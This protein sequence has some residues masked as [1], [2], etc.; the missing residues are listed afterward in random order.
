MRLDMK[1]SGAVAISTLFHTPT[2]LKAQISPDGADGHVFGLEGDRAEDPVIEVISDCIL[3]YFSP[4]VS[5]AL[6]RFL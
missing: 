3:P 2:F 5:G 6:P 1:T 4:L